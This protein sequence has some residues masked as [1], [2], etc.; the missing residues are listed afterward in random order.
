M[1]VKPSEDRSLL[2][3][4]IAQEAMDIACEACRVSMF[5]MTSKQRSRANVA[6][7]RQIAMYLAHVV[8]QLTLGEISIAFERD[9]TT[10]GYAVHLVEDRR[11]GPFFDNQLEQME[12]EMRERMETLY[13]RYRLRGAPTAIDVRLARMHLVRA[14]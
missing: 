10:V 13:S 1:R 2:L 14:S 3:G 8:G 4:L 11:D 5:D 7:A 12:Y 9:R 6:H